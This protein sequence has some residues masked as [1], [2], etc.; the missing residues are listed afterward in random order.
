[1]HRADAATVSYSE[2][3]V[4]GR[5]ASLRYHSTSPCERAAPSVLRLSRTESE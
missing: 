4:S 2:I 1:M 5:V 3:V